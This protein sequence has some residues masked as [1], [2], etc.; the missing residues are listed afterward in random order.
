MLKLG[1]GRSLDPLQNYL[2]DSAQSCCPSL[3]DDD[4]PYYS[5]Y[6]SAVVV[7]V[8]VAVVAASAVKPEVYGSVVARPAAEAA[9][10][11]AAGDVVNCSSYPGLSAAVFRP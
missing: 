1:R 10:G 11:A 5:D 4:W 7:A 6:F 9:A 3:D 8:V 2:L